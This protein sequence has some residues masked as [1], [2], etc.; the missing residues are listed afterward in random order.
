[1]QTPPGQCGIEYLVAAQTHTMNTITRNKSTFILQT[2]GEEVA[3]VKYNRENNSIRIF[4]S[5]RRLFFLNSVGLLQNR[6]LLNTEYGVTIGEI[7][8]KNSRKGA[9][10]FG[11][12]KF[13]YN[14]ADNLLEIHDK[15]RRPVLNFNL[16]VGEKPDSYQTAGILFT[17]IWL[18]MHSD[19]SAATARKASVLYAS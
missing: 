9:V 3:N 2:G 14:I 19:L 12:D 1:M 7:Y 13:F 6:I 18:M 10:H 5:E 11:D 8:P 16:A 4:S 17:A 15:K